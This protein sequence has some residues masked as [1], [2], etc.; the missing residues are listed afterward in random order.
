MDVFIREELA[1]RGVN[2]VVGDPTTMSVEALAVALGNVALALIALLAAVT[3]AARGLG[4][5]LPG[6]LSPR[7]S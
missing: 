1:A 7:K 5:P 4:L 3:P 6:P 2:A